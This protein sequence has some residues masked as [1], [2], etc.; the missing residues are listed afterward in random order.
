MA[1]PEDGTTSGQHGHA[2]D[3]S[4]PFRLQG[5]DVVPDEECQCG[6]HQVDDLKPQSAVTLSSGEQLDARGNQLR[7][8]FRHGNRV[9]SASAVPDERSDKKTSASQQSCENDDE[10]DVF[11]VES[12]AVFF[13]LEGTDEDVDEDDDKESD[14][15]APGKDPFLKSVLE[16]D[17]RDAVLCALEDSEPENTAPEGE[18]DGALP[19]DDTDHPT[20]VQGR[21][22]RSHPQP[23]PIFK[24][25]ETSSSIMTVCRHFNSQLVFRCQV[26]SCNM[27]VSSS[28][29]AAFSSRW[30]DVV[31]RGST[32]RGCNGEQLSE[33]MDLCYEL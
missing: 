17:E 9:N 16:N 32:A 12:H 26:N 3:T 10:S 11:D 2:T 15:S 8:A 21:R 33:Y 30:P 7:I 1:G 31:S 25:R 14:L 23:I 29:P 20:S 13:S 18:Q 6:D 4:D 22:E 5:N 19:Q 28:C 27:R 24:E